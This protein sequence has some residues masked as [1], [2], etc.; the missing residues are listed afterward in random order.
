[1]KIEVATSPPGEGGYSYIT[2]PAAVTCRETAAETLV[3]LIN[4]VASGTV[5]IN[6]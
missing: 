4:V 3:A 1:V 6:D 5:K 2:L